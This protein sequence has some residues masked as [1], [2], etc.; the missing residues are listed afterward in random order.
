MVSWFKRRGLEKARIVHTKMVARSNKNK[1]RRNIK[2][3]ILSERTFWM[4][5]LQGFYK[6]NYY[7]HTIVFETAVI[8]LQ[9]TC[10]HSTLSTVEERP[11]TLFWCCY[12][13]YG[14]GI[15]LVRSEEK[16]LWII[17]SGT[18]LLAIK[19]IFE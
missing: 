6:C 10:L 2:F 4:A 13:R 12:Y 17:L 11:G 14:T 1:W 7:F 9:N 16:E 5:P 19:I 8:L 15:C 18:T 3:I